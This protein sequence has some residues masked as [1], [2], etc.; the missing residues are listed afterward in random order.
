MRHP[1]TLRH[2]LR[3]RQDHTELW[4]A[5]QTAAGPIVD[6]EP[7]AIKDIGPSVP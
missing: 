4:K 6:A 1:V 2:G 7:L 5:L 3:F